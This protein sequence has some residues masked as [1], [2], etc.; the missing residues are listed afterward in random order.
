MVD[1]W[2]VMFCINEED[3]NGGWSFV[4]AKK[5]KMVSDVLYDQ[6]D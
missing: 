5:M 4:W 1:S 2:W 3:E 6:E